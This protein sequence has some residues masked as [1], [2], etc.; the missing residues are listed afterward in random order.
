M[1]LDYILRNCSTFVDGYGLHG[2]TSKI[3]LPKLVEINEEHRGGGMDAPL[4][5]ALGHEKLE[6]SVET[7]D[8][9]P[10]V[11]RLWGLA[12]GTV[13]AFTHKGFLVGE[14][15]GDRSAEVHMR[16][17]V[18]ELDFGDWEPGSLAKLNYSLT[19]RYIKFSIGDEVLHEIDVVAGIRIVNGIDQNIAMR[20]ALGMA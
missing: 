13:K 15:G 10:R 18:K 20:A 2:A 7:A 4:D 8:L 19:L 1:A 6:S 14:D 16:G 3:T 5:I 17:R 9:D 11:V 12:P